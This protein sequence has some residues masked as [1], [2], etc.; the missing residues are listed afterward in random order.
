MSSSIYEFI[1]HINSWIDA[2]LERTSSSLDIDA[3]FV[4]RLNE[5]TQA[6]EFT[7]SKNPD[8]LLKY[9]NLRDFSIRE[10]LPD[11]FSSLKA[12]KIFFDS[13]ESLP[14]EQFDYLKKYNIFTAVF[15][16]IQNKGTL[17]GCLCCISSIKRRVWRSEDL[18]ILLKESIDLSSYIFLSEMLD[19]LKDADEQLAWML[20]EVAEGIA[21]SDE[22]LK[23]TSVSGRI[24]E[25]G[26]FIQDELLGRT[27]WDFIHPDDHGRAKEGLELCKRGIRNVDEYRFVLKSGIILTTR[28]GARPITK[29]GIHKGFI[30][31]IVM[32]SAPTTT[33][34]RLLEYQDYMS[35]ISDLVW[36]TDMNL[37]F[38]Y[39]SPS[40]KYLLGYD[41]EDL[42]KFNAGL[43]LTDK[44]LQ[45]LAEGFARGIASSKEKDGQYRTVI[46]VEQYRQDGTL[47]Y[48]ELLL[49]LRHDQNGN[50]TGFLGVTHFNTN[51]PFI[52]FIKVS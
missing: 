3:A 7:W 13:P 33:E 9:G 23:V 39:V 15:V 27:I 16:P 6:T 18:S 52:D 26:G 25:L 29:K 35:Y 40:I 14:R 37:F 4:F 36:T 20:N 22:N 46:P 43:T 30:F 47:L 32:L 28:I 10:N 51:Q 21:V 17:W 31:L 24:A 45:N 42:L 12:L 49:T 11:V 2:L 5:I 44:T 38:T 1:Q 34:V 19:E 8:I 48:G 41:I 50:P